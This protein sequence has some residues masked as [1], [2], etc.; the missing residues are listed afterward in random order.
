MIEG[1][2]KKDTKMLGFVFET[3]NKHGR[4][5]WAADA[6][7]RATNNKELVEPTSPDLQ[8]LLEVLNDYNTK[9]IIPDMLVD[10][11]SRKDCYFSTSL[12]KLLCYWLN[13]THLSRVDTRVQKEFTGGYHGSILEQMK[14]DGQDCG[15]M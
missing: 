7:S 8:I 3:Q 14:R 12:I 6:L 4:E 13:F 10:P 9:K 1:E 2:Q 11:A 5:N 15:K